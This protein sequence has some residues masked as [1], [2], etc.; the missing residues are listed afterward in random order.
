MI[1]LENGVRTLTEGTL[2]KRELL[3][4]FKIV[5]YQE[6]GELMESEDAKRS[7]KGIVSFRERPDDIKGF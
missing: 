2:A 3:S 7:G 6:N 4:Q 1:C 5:T